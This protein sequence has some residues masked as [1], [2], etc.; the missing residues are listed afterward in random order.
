MHSR[1]IALD[2]TLFVVCRPFL[3]SEFWLEILNGRTELTLFQSIEGAVEFLL[4]NNG[5]GHKHCKASF[6][7]LG[8]MESSW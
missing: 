5:L 8:E 6:T 4:L 2:F 7:L 3:Q 1:R